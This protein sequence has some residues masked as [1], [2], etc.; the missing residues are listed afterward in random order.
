MKQRFESAHHY[1][2]HLSVMQIVMSIVTSLV[3]QALKQPRQCANKQLSVC[4]VPVL[5]QSF[6][7]LPR[8][9]DGYFTVQLLS[10]SEV[11]PQK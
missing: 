9:V 3:N 5:T 7:P 10:A 8:G 6:F 4:T 2:K 1:L 11:D